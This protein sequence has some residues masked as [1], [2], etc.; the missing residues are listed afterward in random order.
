MWAN[1]V[2]VS[3][4]NAPTH[5]EANYMLSSPK[6]RDILEDYSQ[7]ATG[8]PFYSLIEICIVKNNSRA[9]AAQQ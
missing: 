3:C 5:M 9:L 8:S 1:M 6:I 2:E 4:D 7:D